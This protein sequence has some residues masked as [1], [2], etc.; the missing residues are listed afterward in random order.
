MYQYIESFID[1]CCEELCKMSEI[2]VYDSKY[3]WKFAPPPF[4]DMCYAKT[5]PMTPNF[6]L[7]VK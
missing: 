4:V 7:S 2:I 5:K 1:I 6:F 3:F